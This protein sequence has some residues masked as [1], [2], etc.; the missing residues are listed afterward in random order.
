MTLSTD[1]T[2]FIEAHTHYVIH[3]VPMANLFLVIHQ[4]L[5]NT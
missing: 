5:T 3:S 1:L 4:A 2:T